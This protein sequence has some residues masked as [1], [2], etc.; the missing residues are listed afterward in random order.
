MPEI[1]IRPA[2]SSDIPAL[3][4][5]DHHY[6]S[7]YV[8]QMELETEENQIKVHFRQVKLP[9]S[10]RVEYPRPVSS[11]ADDW[12]RRSGILVA[13]HQGETVGYI[14]LNLQ[15]AP[16]TTWATDLAVI[17]RLRRQGIG[18][19]LV[20]AAEEWGLQH[21]TRR[22]VLEMQPKNYPANQMAHKLG[23]ELCG[24]NDNYYA[25][26]DIALFYGKSL[27]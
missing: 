25:N 26:H 13:V 9:R 21:D 4:A 18:S 12:T 27:R 17:R 5:L 22:I 6:S 10:V 3:M 19:A 20:L 24:F 23:F 15:L 7:D 14:S 8:W 2:I 16:C 1:E 11:L